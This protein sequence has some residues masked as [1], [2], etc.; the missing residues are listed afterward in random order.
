MAIGKWSM[1]LC[2]VLFLFIGLGSLAVAV[3]P[4]VDDR[5][6]DWTVDATGTPDAFDDD[7]SAAIADSEGVQ[8]TAWILAATFLPTALL[9][10]WCGR[11]FTSMQP[12]AGR[13]SAPPAGAVP[14]QPYGAQPGVVP[15]GGSPLPP[16]TPPPVP[17]FGDPVLEPPDPTAG[18]IVS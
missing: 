11:W 18:G 17:R 9:F 7:V 3:A 12:G 4:G 8:S 10:F 14:Y 16:D 6:A 15:T 5:V 2:G 13:F 1:Y